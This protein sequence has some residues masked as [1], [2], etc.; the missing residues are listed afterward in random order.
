PVK[1]VVA[2]QHVLEDQELGGFE[3]ATL[4]NPNPT[5]MRLA[6]ERL[7]ASATKADLILLFFSGHG[8]TDDSQ[9]LYLTTRLSLRASFRSTAVDARFIQDLS[10]T[11]YAKRQV[12][13]LDCCYSGAF[14][15]GWQRKGDIQLNLKRELGKEG[16]VVLTSSSSTQVSFQQEDGELSLYTQYL[17]E[18]IETGAADSDKDGVIRVRELHEY[19]RRKVQE[20][21]PKLKP[22]II[23]AGDEGYDI[24][25]SR[26]RRDRLQEF[27][28][29]VE[30]YVDHEQ[31]ELRSPRCR[32]IL[33]ARTREWDIA[34][35]D[36][37][38]TIDSVL[39]PSRRRLRSLAQ[40]LQEYAEEIAAQGYPLDAATEDELRDWQQ[41]VLGLEDQDVA[42]VR[43]AVEQ[44]A[45]RVVT[46]FE[47]WRQR[48]ELAI[49]TV[50]AQPL[51]AR[52]NLSTLRGFQQSLQLPEDVTASM[53]QW[54]AAIVH[55][56][57]KTL[58]SAP[59]PE[60]TLDSF[61]FETAQIIRCQ[62]KGG[63][64]GIGREVFC[65]V[66]R[67]TK[68]AQGFTEVLGDD[69]AL[70]MVQI[71]AGRF[72]M[73]SSNQESRSARE[74]P[75]RVVQVASFCIGKFA[76]TQA[77]YKAVMGENPATEYDPDRFVSSDKPVVGVSWHDAI[78]FCDKL[79]QQTGRNYR[80]PSEAEWEYACRAGT[81]TPFHFGEMTAP[82]LANYDSKSVGQQG[83]RGESLNMPT[84]VGTFSAN[85][86][87]LFD[88]HGN[89][90][91]W[92]TDAWYESYEN[93]P[94]DGSARVIGKDSLEATSIHSDRRV[95]RGGSWNVRPRGCRSAFRYWFCRGDRFNDIGFRVCY[96]P[97]NSVYL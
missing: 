43:Q 75:Q 97:A 68:S 67:E 12:I 59:Y 32:E 81:E 50:I 26:A 93:A 69:V 19:A 60:P 27:R 73:G 57:R 89:V 39:E 66:K 58:A 91:E 40:Y 23:V 14:A 70:E 8:V 80:L 34:P 63:F 48:I 28:L 21:K 65:D 30:K 64:L 45:E 11:T 53:I 55:E 86:F 83:P 42:P 46:R 85:A 36:M 7:F 78:A 24:V 13:I 18:G 49:R 20:V 72:T 82:T 10:D 88:M 52:I 79:S 37:A 44:A 2:L 17:V 76:I 5:E 77:Q 4:E 25:L 56:A 95:V 29:L 33:D 61:D 92:C 54:T 31:G 6:I 90:W 16:R 96:S 62:R 41:V 71:P 94:V 51:P 87:G 3:V 35:E 47:G 22:D 74:K 84:V 9:R 15:E 38:R 1:D